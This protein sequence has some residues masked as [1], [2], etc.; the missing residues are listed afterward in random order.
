MNAGFIAKEHWVQTDVGAGR[1]IGEA[2]HIV[3]L[4]CFLTDAKPLS[5]SVESLASHN[6]NLFPTDNFSAQF[7]FD[8]GSICTLLYTSLG[9]NQMGKERMEL[10]FDSKSIVMNDYQCLT[11]FGLP[12]SF[13][14]KTK[15]PDKGHQALLRSFFTAITQPE[16][17]VMPIS[18][19]RLAM[20]AHL[21]LVVD[22]LACQGGGSRTIG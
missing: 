14:E 8:D 21:T 9:H 12:H 4:F 16:D 18:Y 2:C 17:R 13:N 20:V 15:S 11:G 5:V 6:E 7:S 10:F 1:I 19:E 3:D 22:Q